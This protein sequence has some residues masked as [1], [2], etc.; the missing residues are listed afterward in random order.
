MRSIGAQLPNASIAVVCASGLAR[1]I[2]S[3]KM[4]NKS[5]RYLWEAAD[6]Q[7]VS[8]RMPNLNHL[9]LN[10]RGGSSI[11]PLLPQKLGSLRLLVASDASTY[12]INAM[13]LCASR[14]PLLA[15]LTLQFNQLLDPR[16]SFV[17]LHASPLLSEF[18]IQ[19]GYRQHMPS[20]EQVR[21][22]RAL[23]H[24]T[25]FGLYSLKQSL[26]ALLPAL[27]LVT[28]V[29]LVPVGNDDV[30]VLRQLPNLHYLCLEFA[31]QIPWTKQ[32]AVLQQSCTRLTTLEIMHGRFNANDLCNLLPCIAGLRK[33]SL[34]KIRT[35]DSLRFLSRGPIVRTLTDLTL[36]YLAH[37]QLHS[38]E[39]LHVN[40]LRELRRLSL[41]HL[42]VEPLDPL[43]QLFYSQTPS[44]LL[45]KLALF[46]YNTT[47]YIP[48]P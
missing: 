46:Q 18:H 33:L 7:L 26:F 30:F 4:L 38:S 23:P 1:H 32:L 11:V 47:R 31:T 24:L 45:P 22:L 25:S 35:I 21:E 44:R 10:M 15:H 13:V 36:G 16:V 17:A 2:G 9:T 43:T 8:D 42:F 27:P 19:F 37:S 14:L 41:Q 5:P 3:I 28:R 40:E 29:S 12:Q 39:M 48:T 20:D 6:L 34:W